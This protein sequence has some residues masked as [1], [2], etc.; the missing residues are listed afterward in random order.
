MSLQE[1]QI[2][3]NKMKRDLLKVHSQAI[4]GQMFTNQQNK[5]NQITEKQI[6]KIK[7][8]QQSEL[9]RQKYNQLKDNRG[10]QVNNTQNFV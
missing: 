1:A 6:E 8:D 7:F 10:S 4:E 3:Q 2:R 5:Q 9:V